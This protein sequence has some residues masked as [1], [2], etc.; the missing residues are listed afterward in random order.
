VKTAHK[1]VDAA[2]TVAAAAEDKISKKTPAL[3]LN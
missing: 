1:V 2:A 3:N